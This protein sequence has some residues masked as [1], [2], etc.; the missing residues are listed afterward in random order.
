M[1]RP[2]ELERVACRV[3]LKRPRH[4]SAALPEAL[5]VN[6]VVV[7]EIDP[8][9]NQP[10]VSWTLITSEPIESEEDIAWIVDAYRARWVIE[11][12]FKALKTGCSFEKRQLESFNALQRALCIY[13]P[14]A[15]QL[16]QIRHLAQVRPDSPASEVIPELRLRLLAA[17]MKSEKRRTLPANPT[18]KDVLFGIACLGG[19]LARNGPPGW[20]TL[21]RGYDE[22]LAAERGV[23][24]LASE[25]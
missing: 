1:L 3:S 23:L 16:L 5:E 22:L 10:A 17:L 24:A 20:Q 9:E 4:F 6:V 2:W 13:L 19:H 14:I 25:M 12:L 11:E 8:P 18:I 21:G 15:W 7:R